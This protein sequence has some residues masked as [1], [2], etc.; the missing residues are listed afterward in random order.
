MSVGFHYKQFR[1]LLGDSLSSW[2]TDRREHLQDTFVPFKL[3]NYS[4]CKC[5]TRN[6]K[7]KFRKF[8][9]TIKGTF[10]LFVSRDH[11]QDTSSVYAVSIGCED[12]PYLNKTE[13]CL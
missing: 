1:M 8:I 10:V 6:I 13:F 4:I 2:D 12:I 9:K 5:H 3:E 7:V 11:I